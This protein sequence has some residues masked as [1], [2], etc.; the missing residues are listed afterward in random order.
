MKYKSK[1]SSKDDLTSQGEPTEGSSWVEEYLTVES[2]E[3][4]PEVTREGKTS[5]SIRLELVGEPESSREHRNRTEIQLVFGMEE[6]DVLTFAR[7][8]GRKVMLTQ[9]R[10]NSKLSREHLVRQLEMYKK[11]LEEAEDKIQYLNESLHRS[12]AGPRRNLA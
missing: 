10:E 1:D 11:E 12:V 2:A 8:L 5:F 6:K 3:L 4:F 7:F 9:Q